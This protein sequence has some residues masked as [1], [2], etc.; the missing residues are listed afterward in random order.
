MCGW[1]NR[2]NGS[3]MI[4]VS[5]NT[6]PRYPPG[7]RLRADVHRRVVGVG[8]DQQMVDR[9]PDGMCGFVVADDLAVRI[10]PQLLPPPHRFGFRLVETGAASTV[11]SARA[12]GSASEPGSRP[13]AMPTSLSTVT[14]SP[15]PVPR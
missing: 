9:E 14:R 8:R 7:Q 1:V 13:V 15:P 2:K 3:I 10:G 12:A 5:Q 11:A 4:S 6:C